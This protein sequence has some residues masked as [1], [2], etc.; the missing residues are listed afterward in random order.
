MESAVC[1]AGRRYQIVREG[2]LYRVPGK[3]TYVAEPKIRQIRF[4]T[5]AYANSSN[6]GYK[7][8]PNS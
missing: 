8:S 1:G 4:L 5:K 7:R 2:L 3:G 6:A